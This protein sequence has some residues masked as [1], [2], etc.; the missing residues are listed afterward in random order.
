MMICITMICGMMILQQII[1]RA[2]GT[3]LGHRAYRKAQWRVLK[4]MFFKAFK[5]TLHH[6]EQI[7]SKVSKRR[8]V[9]DGICVAF[10]KG[11]HGEW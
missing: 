8:T 11:L 10:M 1:I 9:S 4:N 6:T 3:V 7:Y 5:I 2:Y